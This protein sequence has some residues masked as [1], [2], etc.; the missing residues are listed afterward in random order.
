MES[1]AVLSRRGGRV[2]DRTRLES[3]RTLTGTGSS[4]LPL[5]ASQT[6]LQPAQSTQVSNGAFG[7]LWPHVSGPQQRVPTNGSVSL[8]L[9]N[10]TPPPFFAAS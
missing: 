9:T 2:V 10:R 8:V 6:F 1:G 5:S 4:N 3:G 7:I